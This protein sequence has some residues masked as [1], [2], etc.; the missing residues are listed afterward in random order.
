MQIG[1]WTGTD[2]AVNRPGFL[3]ARHRLGCAFGRILYQ[4]AV[5]YCGGLVVATPLTPTM[6]VLDEKPISEAV[7]GVGRRQRIGR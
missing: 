7:N 2:G 3:N 1:G 4:T 6:R 5:R